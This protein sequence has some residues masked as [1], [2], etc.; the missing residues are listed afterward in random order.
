MTSISHFENDFLSQIGSKIGLYNTAKAKQW[1]AKIHI[2]AGARGANLTT[3]GAFKKLVK[4]SY[5][6][7]RT[8]SFSSGKV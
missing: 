3:V 6:E 2:L 1:K 8:M 7:P 5:V 4:E